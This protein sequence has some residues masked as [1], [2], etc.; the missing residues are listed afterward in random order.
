MHIHILIHVFSHAHT[1]THT[2]EPTPPLTRASVYP[3][4]SQVQSA[5][6]E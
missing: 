1:H 5:N 2:V 3:F 4:V 6:V